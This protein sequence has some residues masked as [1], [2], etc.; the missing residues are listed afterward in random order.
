LNSNQTDSDD[1]VRQI[2]V[3][4]HRVLSL[5]LYKDRQLTELRG[6]CFQRRLGS[7]LACDKTYNLGAIY[8]TPTVYVNQALERTATGA[9][10]IFFGPIFLH[11]HSDTETY[12]QFFGHLSGCI[13]D[14]NFSELTWGSD[15]EQATRKSFKHFFPRSSSVICTRHLKENVRHYLSDKIGVQSRDRTGNVAALLDDGGLVSCTEPVSF[16]N[17]VD[18]F[19]RDFLETDTR[20]AHEFSNYFDSTNKPSLRDNMLAGRNGWTSNHCESMNN[21]LKKLSSVAAREAS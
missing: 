14:C 20:E 12:N 16:A 4:K 8:V 2:N 17:A 5:I 10:P 9:K 11:G 21:V 6:F 3:V 7:V 18:R 15:Q 13:M 1:S 19:W